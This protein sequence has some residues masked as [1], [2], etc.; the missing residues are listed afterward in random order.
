MEK[1]LVIL[2]ALMCC[3]CL[4]SDNANVKINPFHNGENDDNAT[5]TCYVAP[6]VPEDRRTNKSKLTVASFNAEWLFLDGTQCPGSGCP[7][8][9]K[10]QAE[11]HLNHVASV[12]QEINADIVGFQEVQ[13]CDVLQQLV[14]RIPNGGYK[15]YLIK[16]TDTATGQN[17]GIITRID[18]FVNLQRTSERVNFPISGST[19][20]Y[21]TPGDSAVSKHLY[22]QFKVGSTTIFFVVVHFVAFPTTPDRCAQREAQAS[23]IRNLVST[24]A[25]AN[26][27]VIIVGDYNDYDGVVLDVNND[28]PISRVLQF[29]KSSR[30]PALNTVATIVSKSNRYSSWWDKNSNCVVTSDELTTIDHILVSNGLWSKVANGT[31]AH[32]YS[33]SCTNF[34]PD[35]WPVLVTFNT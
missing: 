21:N 22:T 26:N 33:A 17:V 23:V 3:A 5:Y 12:V 1:I 20:N 6:A 13:D 18:P 4:A 32:D 9:N 11:D 35:H 29:M 27:E 31:Y 19:C 24:T 34:F 7:W 2:V 8:S 30:S 28:M 15:Y 16:G 10:A 25:P 14:A